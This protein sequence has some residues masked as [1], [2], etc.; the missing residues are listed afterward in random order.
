MLIWNFSNIGLIPSQNERTA[1]E[2]FLKFWY[3]STK[4]YG[5][6]LHQFENQGVQFKVRNYLFSSFNS[7]LHDF[8]EQREAI[9]CKKIYPRDNLTVEPYKNG[10]YEYRCRGYALLEF[11]F[12]VLS[13]NSSVMA[14]QT[15]IV[16]LRIP[17]AVK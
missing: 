14:L 3:F 12:C 8:F 1:W 9:E 15:K 7:L 16:R 13:V 6:L 5:V 2:C 10:R 17:R 11:Y 4:E